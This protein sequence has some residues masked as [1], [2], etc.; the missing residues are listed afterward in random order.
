[1]ASDVWR[2][3]VRE[4]T[5]LEESGKRERLEMRLEAEKELAAKREELEKEKIAMQNPETY[6]MY[7]QSKKE[8]AELQARKM[9]AQLQAQKEKRNQEAAEA[10]SQRNHGL[11]MFLICVALIV[12]IMLILLASEGA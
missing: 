6:K 10:R 12:I 2:Q 5:W 3:T 9:E 8:E 1:M 4:Q 7:L 11:K